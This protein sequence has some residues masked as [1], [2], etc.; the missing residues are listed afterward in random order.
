MLIDELIEQ[1]SKKFNEKGVD[2]EK[3]SHA[4]LVIHETHLEKLKA[5]AYWERITIK[6]ILDQFLKQSFATL[7][8]SLLKSPQTSPSS[9]W[10]RTSSEIREKHLVKLK[11]LSALMQSS[12]Q[13][14][15]YQLLEIQLS[16]I[17]IKPIP[18]MQN[19]V[20]S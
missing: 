16:T 5:L 20:F 13:D 10:K 17:K 12:M 19:G 11:I 2:S 1:L 7:E 6:S 8:K 14:I 18:K 3:W 9:G 15:L 4:P